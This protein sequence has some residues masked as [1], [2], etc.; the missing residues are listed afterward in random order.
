[1]WS[2][3]ANA[4]DARL[5]RP[6]KRGRGAG[7]PASLAFVMASVTVVLAAT[8]QPSFGVVPAEGGMCVTCGELWL[9]DLVAN[10]L[11]FVPFGVALAARGRRVPWA[12]GAALALSVS[13]E[14]LQ[15]FVPGRSPVL[16]DVLA[17]GSGAAL[18]AAAVTHAR[19]WI[20]PVEAW[21]GVLGAAA[22]TAGLATVVGSAW[23]R[24]PAM[25]HS[26][27]AAAW[28]EATQPGERPYP[29]I[30]LEA[31][32]GGEP[33][34]DGERVA[35]WAVADF[36]RGA[37]PLKLTAE[38]APAHPA[39]R[40][41]FSLLNASGDPHLRVE[42]TGAEMIVR[43][44]SR[45]SWI[46]LAPV[47][48][49][50][51][52]DASSA[53]PASDP[54]DVVLSREGGRL[55]ASVAG[56]VSCR[57][58]AALEDGWTLF[59]A[60]RASRGAA[61]LVGLV[62]LALLF[63]PAGLWLGPG[64]EGRPSARPR[65]CP[66]LCGTAAVICALALAGRLVGTEAPALPAILA[67]VVGLVLGRQSGPWLARTATA[68]RGRAVAVSPADLGEPRGVASSV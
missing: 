55:C 16:R 40:T 42:V 57:P 38:R 1:M 46:G 49:P 5:E 20:A 35:G 66:P 18:G 10:V 48:L 31:G 58:L 28:N 44:R 6:L 23:L 13:V 7:P 54:I 37:V 43:T 45:G 3:L 21:R 59:H 47:T 56:R 9:A 2:A 63:A 34:G 53:A 4:L 65:W 61:T 15:N 68:R 29:G 12:L 60:G 67:A 14:L 8:L 39:P 41:L 11:L 33:I 30:V 64:R 17:N 50:F 32:L 25:P 26:A 24:Q 27:L 19:L 22:L 62:W 36:L 51:D 52:L